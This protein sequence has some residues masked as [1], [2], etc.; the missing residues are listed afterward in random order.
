[1]NNTIGTPKL[2]LL[3]LISTPKLADKASALIE[4]A[5]IPLHYRLGAMG[6]ASSEMMDILG[7]GSSEKGVLAAVSEKG[8][9]DLILK[10]LH[11]ELKL[12]T[13][14]SGIAFTA[15]LNGVSNFLLHIAESASSD[16]RK[17]NTIMSESNYTMIAAIVNPGF[18]DN[19][20][21]VARSAGAGGGSVIHSRRIS[22]K[23]NIA[24]WGLNVQEEKEI[25]LIIA[26]NDSK[27]E[28]MQAI[29]KEC[30]MRSDANGMVI[31]LPI[32]SVIGLDDE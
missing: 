8:T 6:T 31:S 28:I 24:F 12:G 2:R 27:L 21:N 5:K 14:N 17:D 11:K 26:K 23:K 29:G 15:P 3:M 22:D 10:R 25:V 16:D 1:M 13:V 18:S 7:L 32:E 9:A 4:N 20:M 19:V 30:G